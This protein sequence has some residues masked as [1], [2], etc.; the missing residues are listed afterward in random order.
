MK[1]SAPSVAHVCDDHQDPGAQPT[2][3][4][5]DVIDCWSGSALDVVRRPWKPVPRESGEYPGLSREEADRTSSMKDDSYRRSVCAARW[6][7]SI[8]APQSWR[9]TDVVPDGE[10]GTRSKLLP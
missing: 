6:P 7:P 5:T 3:V 1:Y 8:P 9:E 4:P 10:R 2:P